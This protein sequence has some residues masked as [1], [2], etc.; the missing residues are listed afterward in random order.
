MTCSSVDTNLEPP[1]SE[2]PVSLTF[3]LKLYVNGSTYLVRYNSHLKLQV[4]LHYTTR[5]CEWLR[6]S[7]PGCHGDRCCCVLFS[8]FSTNY[9]TL[10]GMAKTNERRR[11]KRLR[12]GHTSMTTVLSVR[13]E[14][15]LRKHL[16]IECVIQHNAARW[17]REYNA[18]PAIINTKLQRHLK[19][20]IGSGSTWQWFDYSNNLV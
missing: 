12:M 19:T 2:Y 15:N 6:E 10:I 9:Y 1:A 20:S 8:L 17:Q 5:L 14:Q 4:N 18:D 11:R 7:R 16:S 3:I 13:C